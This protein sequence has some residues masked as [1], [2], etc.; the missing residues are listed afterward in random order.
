MKEIETKFKIK[1]PKEIIDKLAELGAKQTYVQKEHDV[2]FVSGKC[3]GPVSTIRVRHLDDNT[4]VFTI[5]KNVPNQEKNIKIKEEIEVKV[6][7]AQKMC[8]MLRDIGF[9]QR[10]V[11]EKKRTIYSIENSEVC[12]DKMPYIGWYVEIEAPDIQTI[13]NLAGKLGFD[14][15]KAVKDT[16]MALF[17]LY[18]II[19][20][21][22][23]LEMLFDQE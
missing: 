23:D 7:D 17:N 9:K 20:R 1:D 13:E 8:G 2:Y 15:D 10:F 19:K 12:I 5:K 16:Y 21:K 22:P 6:D 4:G 14:M 18:K 3:Q 11:K